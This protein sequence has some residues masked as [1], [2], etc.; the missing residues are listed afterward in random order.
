MGS[1]GG[2]VGG[3]LALIFSWI[4]GV[5]KVGMLIAVLVAALSLGMCVVFFYS[6]SDRTS[7]SSNF[8]LC[9][10]FFSLVCFPL[11]FCHPE[12]R[13]SLCSVCMQVS[14]HPSR[15]VRERRSD[16]S[17]TEATGRAKATNAANSLL[18]LLHNNNLGG[19]DL[20]KHIVSTTNFLPKGPSEDEIHG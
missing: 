9:S 17:A 12:G 4:S 19:I 6:C 2:G 13:R 5:E 7:L 20:S 11:D 15:A 14:L 1:W 8:V 10:S 16:A 3:E 18:E